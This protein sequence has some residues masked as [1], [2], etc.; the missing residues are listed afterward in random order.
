MTPIYRVRD[1]K[2]NDDD[3]NIK[4]VMSFFSRYKFA[5]SRLRS[6]N[7]IKRGSDHAITET[8]NNGIE[9]K[10]DNVPTIAK[11]GKD[12][13][14]LKISSPPKYTIRPKISAFTRF[15]TKRGSVP[16]IFPI[17]ANSAG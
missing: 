10:I 17:T 1:N 7:N 6:T 4:E 11:T 12:D 15:A 13:K 5:N 16:K 14:Y 3:R 9:A 2:A 8:E